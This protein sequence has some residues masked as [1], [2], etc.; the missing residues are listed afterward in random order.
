MTLPKVTIYTDGS[1]KPNPGPG[2]WGAVLIHPGKENCTQRK[3]CEAETTNNRMELMA[4]IKALQSLGVPHEVL[5][6]T[7]S[8]YLKNGITEWIN[9]WK[10]Q[11]WKTRDGVAVKNKDLWMVLDKERQRHSITWKWERGHSD[12]KWNDLADQL[13]GSARSRIILP[14]DNPDAV[15][16]FLGVTW[17]H[18]TGKGAWALVFKYRHYQKVDVG[19]VEETTANRLYIETATRG[20]KKIT[21]NLPVYLY[22]SSG[23]LRDGAHGWLSGWSRRNWET[24]DGKEVSNKSQWQNLKTHLD[25]MKVQVIL[26]EKKNQPCLLQEA[27]ELARECDSN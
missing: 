14:L 26:V 10:R 3:G 9:G 27:K 17:K 24:R 16:I 18:S 11:G 22:T 25:K 5:L 20:L 2:G 7:D 19:R 12:N 13:A 4:P 1:C 21:R 6:I 23:Y 8:K 15:H